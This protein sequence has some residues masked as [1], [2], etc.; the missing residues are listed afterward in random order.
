M[1][2]LVSGELMMWQFLSGYFSEWRI[3]TWRNLVEWRV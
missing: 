2:I 1:V 3:A